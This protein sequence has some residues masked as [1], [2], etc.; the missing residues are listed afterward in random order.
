MKRPASIR[1]KY[2]AAATLILLA[3]LLG[4]AYAQ[5]RG[6]WGGFGRR[7]D[8]RNPEQIRENDLMTKAI[9]PAFKEDVFTFARLRFDAER[10]FQFGGGRLWDDDSPEAD[11]NVI[12]RLYE[13][14]SLK[15]R[16]GLEFH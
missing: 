7:L 5:F 14:T 3:L 6:G 12:F 8:M 9:N 15:V 1:L 11:L 10:G 13:T 2:A 4:E 16:P